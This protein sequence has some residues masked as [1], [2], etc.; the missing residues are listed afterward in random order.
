MKLF[1][2]FIPFLVLSLLFVSCEHEPEFVHDAP[3]NLK[4]W[5]S[6]SDSQY[7]KGDFIFN[8]TA[9][10]VIVR[11]NFD[12]LADTQWSF[13]VKIPKK[14]KNNKRGIEYLGFKLMNDK[15]GSFLNDVDFSSKIVQ[16]LKAQFTSQ[17]TKIVSNN[18]KITHK[19]DDFFEM[20]GDIK[21]Y[22]EST[23]FPKDSFVMSFTN[24]L[25]EKSYV[26]VWVNGSVVTPFS[27]DID[28]KAGNEYNP[29]PT[30]VIQPEF[31]K[32]IQIGLGLVEG[33]SKYEIG[34]KEKQFTNF[35]SGSE[36]WTA[37]SGYFL[38]DKFYYKDI[39]KANM[40]I[41][42]QSPDNMNNYSVDSVK[43]N[44][45]RIPF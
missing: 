17:Q 9:G 39:I 28:L 41:N 40:K 45:S 12:I 30:I 32:S 25:V 43:I 33:K 16:S 35:K 11:S 44:Y 3:V 36:I 34:P 4:S 38:F 31:K 19:G 1:I 7:C 6:Y 13:L 14:T 15:I 5:L 21:V 2:K 22:T 18:F 23:E 42:Y 37:N 27:W 20:N 26:R 10:S 24:I 29:E 8:D